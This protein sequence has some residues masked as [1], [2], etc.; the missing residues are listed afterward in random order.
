MKLAYH[1]SNWIAIIILA[2]FVSMVINA[3]SSGAESVFVVN[4]PLKNIAIDLN[5]SMIANQEQ[6]LKLMRE[7][8]SMLGRHRQ[9]IYDPDLRIELKG[10]PHYHYYYSDINLAKPYD[11]LSQF[12]RKVEIWAQSTQTVVRVTIDLDINRQFRVKIIQRIKNRI[13][14]R[15]E[16]YLVQKEV[17]RL[18]KIALVEPPPQ[19]EE[20][21]LL[22]VVVSGLTFLN[23]AVEYYREIKRIKNAD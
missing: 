16:C 7:A 10:Y 3:V 5:E 8:M 13:I 21:K 9:Y 4:K 12:H 15:V 14:A 1:I 11:K 2:I 19:P 17:D 18:C 20:D 22:K 6:S 23:D